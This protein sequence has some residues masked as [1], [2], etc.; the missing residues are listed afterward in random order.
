MGTRD[1]TARRD[2]ATR[3]ARLFGCQPARPY[4]RGLRSLGIAALGFAHTADDAAHRRFLALLHEMMGC[5]AAALTPQQRWNVINYISALRQEKLN[6]PVARVDAPA[7][8][9]RS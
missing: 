1:R 2:R 9:I 5:D 7:L 4:G 8:H 6:L 3:F